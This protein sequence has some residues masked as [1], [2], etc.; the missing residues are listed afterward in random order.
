MKVVNAEKRIIEEP[1]GIYRRNI[2]SFVDYE[3]LEEQHKQKEK[4][5]MIKQNK[6]KN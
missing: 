1:I 6:K 4:A 2:L 5:K 3:D